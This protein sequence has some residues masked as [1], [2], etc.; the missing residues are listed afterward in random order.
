MQATLYAVMPKNLSPANRFE[1]WRNELKAV[2][3]TEHGDTDVLTYGDLPEPEVGPNDVKVRVRACALNRLDVYTRQGAR[4]TR[5][6]FNGPIG[7][8]DVPSGHVVEVGS[9]VRTVAVRERVVVNPAH[10]V[11]Y[12]CRSSW[13]VKKNLV[14]GN[15]GNA[16][17]RI[18]PSIEPCHA[19]DVEPIPETLSMCRAARCQ[20]LLLP[21]GILVRSAVSRRGNLRFHRVRAVGTRH[22]GRQRTYRCEGSA[23][24][25][26]LRT[27]LRAREL[28]RQ[29]D[30][31]TTGT[32]PIGQE[33]TAG[34]A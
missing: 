24:P 34:R 31:Y 30:H 2:Y 22:T 15:V 21:C 23:P 16:Q 3:L 12:E 28:A 20:R 14:A 32:L 27:N 10:N 33:I 17:R 26:A 19:V 25:R 1:I 4:G 8:R 18:R 7:A 5:I 29:V 11:Q 6:R 9:E 13:P